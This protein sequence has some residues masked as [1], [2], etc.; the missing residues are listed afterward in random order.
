MRATV[1]LC[2]V[3]CVSVYVC[4]CMRLPARLSPVLAWEG[5]AVGAGRVVVEEGLARRCGFPL[6]LLAARVYC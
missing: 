4:V 1:C 3:V 2:V 6:P 5:G